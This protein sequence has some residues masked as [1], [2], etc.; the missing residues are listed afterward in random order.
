M[1]GPFLP[2]ALFSPFLFPLVMFVGSEF[3]LLRLVLGIKV[4]SFRLGLEV[5]H[6]E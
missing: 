2:H 3:L 5:S 4:L 1:L 6:L